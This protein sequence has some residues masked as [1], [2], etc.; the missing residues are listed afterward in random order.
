MGRTGRTEFV[1][2]LLAD[3]SSSSGDN[4]LTLIHSLGLLCDERAMVPLIELAEAPDARIRLEAIISLG[5]IGSEAAIPALEK[6][7]YD[8]EPNVRWD[9]AIALAKMGDSSGSHILLDLLNRDYLKSYSEVDADERTE[10][11]LVAIEAAKYLSDDELNEKIKYLSQ[12]DPV[13]R[14]RDEAQK[15]LQL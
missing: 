9:A 2:I 12:N 4:Q 5:N 8:S 1:P 11:I 15:A 6:A 14:V 7:L 3:L 10:A 13:M